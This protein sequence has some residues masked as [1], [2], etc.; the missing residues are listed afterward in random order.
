[1]SKYVAVNLSMPLYRYGVSFSSLS[2]ADLCLNILRYSAIQWCKSVYI[3]AVEPHYRSCTA[4][5]IL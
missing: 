1:M 3:T 2:L 5:G 4:N